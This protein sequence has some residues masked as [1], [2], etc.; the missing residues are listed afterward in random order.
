M[1]LPFA[2][3]LV[4]L[5]SGCGASRSTTPD[6]QGP[7]A[8]VKPGPGETAVQKAVWLSAMTTALPPAMCQG[9][10]YFRQCFDVTEER[11]L[12]AMKLSTKT[13]VEQHELRIPEVLIQP[14]D[15]TTWG[16]VVGSCTGASYETTLATQKKANV[17][18]CNDATAWR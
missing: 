7:N 16:T 14:R 9:E 10:Q 13:C 3:G 18:K 4:L 2:L 17:A 8:D 12:E 6:A 11:C 1:R 5:V 15:G